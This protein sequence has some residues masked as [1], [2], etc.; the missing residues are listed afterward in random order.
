M[1]RSLSFKVK[2]QNFSASPVKIERKKLYG[3]QEKRAY[4]DEGK[5]CISGYTDE[6]GSLLLPMGGV[7]H[8]IS[9]GNGNW[10]E[11]AE[12]AAVYEDG[13]PALLRKSSYSE[14]IHLDAAVTPEQFL[15]HTITAAYQLSGDPSFC[16]VLGNSILTFP[17]T[18][19]DS[20]ETSPA[21]I[22]QSGG[23]VFMLLGYNTN[24]EMISLNQTAELDEE[25]D[26]P[27][28]DEED[29]IDFSMM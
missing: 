25:N 28:E 3:R 24:F 12:L 18:Y 2:G 29:G 21:F 7:G 19:R 14:T 11:R 27:E 22:L 6:S 4:D 9:D 15:N 23:V 20:Y 10:V 16:S 8:G 1:A 17:Y 5:E 13:S 26:E